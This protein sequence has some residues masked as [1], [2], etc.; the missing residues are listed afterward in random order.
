MYMSNVYS[1]ESVWRSLKE[2]LR[3][4]Y[5]PWGLDDLK[6]TLRVVSSEV[7]MG[8]RGPLATASPSLTDS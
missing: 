1:I 3:N 6:C 2:Y 7:V 5:K 4:V 8:E